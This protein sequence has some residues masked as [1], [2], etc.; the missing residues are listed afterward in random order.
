MFFRNT[1]APQE[2]PTPRRAATCLIRIGFLLA[3][4]ALQPAMAAKVATPEIPLAPANAAA[5]TIPSAAD[6]WGGIRSGKEATLSDRVVAYR[7]AAT[8]D[9]VK[10]TVTGKQTLTWRNRSAQSVGSVYLHLYLNAFEGENSTFATER[11]ASKNG[12]RTGVATGDGE[13]GYIELRGVTQGGAKVDWR[14]VHPDGGPDTDHTVVRLDLPFPV[15]AGA[16]TNLEM[17]F[18]DQLPRVVA[19]TGYFGSFHLVGQWFPKIAVLELAGER[20]ATGPRWNAHEMHLESEF[21]ADFG[22]YDVRLTVPKGYTV[23]ATGERQGPPLEQDGMSI[24]HFIQDD[25][26]DFAWTA[27][28][29]TGTPLVET[30]TVPGGGQV[31]VTVLYPKEL[32]SNAAP[33][34]LATKQALNY[35]SNTLGPYPYRTI[36]VVVPPHNADEAG[37]MEYPT[38]VTTESHADVGANTLDAYLTDFTTIHEFGHGYFYGILASNE[39]EEPML[40]EGLNNYWNFRMLRDRPIHLTTSLLRRLGL[41]VAWEGFASERSK[42]PRAAPADAPGQNAYGRLQG[43]TPIYTR[44]S[45]TLRDLEARIGK[46]ATERAFKEYYRRWKFRHP[47]VA[48]LRETLADASGQR[49]IVEQV[50]AQQIYKVATIDDRVEQIDSD[51]VLPQAGTSL[52]DGLRIERR[53]KEVETAIAATRAMWKHAHPDA[54]EGTGPFPFETTVTLRRRGAP[55]RQTLLVKF[56]DG[57]QEK[58]VW[59]D[60]RN[61]ARYTWVRPARAVSAEID[62]EHAHYMDVSKL[63]D[64]KTIAP[65]RTASARWAIDF[66]ALWQMLL[67][68]IASVV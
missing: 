51:E 12:F 58:V 41:D 32:A 22:S 63:D 47:S 33:A 29:R 15:A 13:W 1:A 4:L 53:K 11:R 60:E 42:A 3:A 30:V 24:H 37:G 44:T 52:V 17:S 56:A 61:W 59:D 8:L 20:G 48:D 26:H 19:R 23:G 67:T 64:S 2:N 35:F 5:V 9:P 62:P 65:N 28:N 66:G 55:V 25:V 50:F 10:H 46:D 16:S 6:A 45:G 36:T 7:I 40:D 38:F 34:L 31:T 14:F 39:F 43:M 68:L 54:V 21:Y 27:D 57:T 18:F 49:A